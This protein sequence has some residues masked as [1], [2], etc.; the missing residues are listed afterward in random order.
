MMRPILF[1][2]LAVLL[3][4]QH[5]SACDCKMIPLSKGAIAS[6]EFIFLGKV[7]AISGCDRTSKASFSIQELFRGKSFANTEIEFDCSS[8]CQMSF[9]PGQ[10]W[11][12][13]ATY[14]SY[15]AAEVNFCSYSRQQFAN[16]KDDY[17]TAVHGMDFST[18]EIWLKE[19][20]G[21]LALNSKDPLAEQHH[22]NIH[23]NGFQ[24]LYY[25]GSGFLFLALAYFVGRKY[26]K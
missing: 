4:L 3:S 25:L 19:N 9:A 7:V 23:P 22:E 13:Y 20:L 11:L 6:C 16:E 15:G 21:L 18:E 10:T 2:L 8:D 1:L 26:L 14:K 24:T 17:N 12:I 5:L